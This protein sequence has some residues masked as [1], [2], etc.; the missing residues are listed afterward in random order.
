MPY[1]LITFSFEWV[2]VR[3]WLHCARISSKGCQRWTRRF[4]DQQQ[5]DA[6]SNGCRET[7][8]K[9]LKKII[10]NLATDLSVVDVR[11]ILLSRTIFSAANRTT[12]IICGAKNEFDGK[13]YTAVPSL[14]FQL[15]T[16]KC[17]H[18]I[19]NGL[20]EHPNC[21]RCRSEPVLG[22]G[23]GLGLRS[24]LLLRFRWSNIVDVS[25]AENTDMPIDSPH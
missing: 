17:R 6:T 21:V 12:E 22:V 25:K 5:T 14:G 4:S 8:S 16:D 24:F 15:S 10:R 11:S 18:L 23:V 3:K 2:Y 9:N 1:R 20:V 13:I 7:S 19:T